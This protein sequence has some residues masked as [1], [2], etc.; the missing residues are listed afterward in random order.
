MHVGTGCKQLAPGGP[1]APTATQRF[2]TATT[3]SW[4]CTT[5]WSSPFSLAATEVVCQQRDVDGV[6]QLAWHKRAERSVGAH[7]TAVSSAASVTRPT[8]ARVQRRD[9]FGLEELFLVVGH[10]PTHRRSIIIHRVG[11]ECLYPLS[12]T[13]TKTLKRNYTVQAKAHDTTTLR[14]HHTRPY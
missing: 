13:K 10:V 4:P 14:H 11:R 6:N 12:D 3:T 9:G 2:S 8:A 1:W 5:Q 7:S